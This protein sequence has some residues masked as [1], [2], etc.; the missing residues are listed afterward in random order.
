MF[1]RDWFANPMPIADRDTFIAA[2]RLQPVRAW[3]LAWTES[4]HGKEPDY[5]VGV[6]LGYDRESTICYIL[7]V[8]RGRWSPA[9]LEQVIVTT[10]VRDGYE[11]RIRIPQDAGAGKFVAHYMAKKLVR[12][13]V[14]IEPEVG[15]GNKAQRAVSFA[16]HCE[17]RFVV[18][19]QADWNT[20][21]VDELCAFPNGVNDDQV[22]AAA[23][24]F[25]AAARR[26]QF[27]AVG[28]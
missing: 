22:N 11:Y 12:F 19:A 10:A 5:S 21:F 13:A 14:T 4:E 16:A 24:A 25:R 15:M 9:G 26:P 7:D 27:Y 6:L 3:D 2:K 23:A 8:A 28:A 18:L 20:A 17:N 1:K